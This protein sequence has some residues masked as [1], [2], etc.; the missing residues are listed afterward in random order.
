M[1]TIIIVTILQMN[2]LSPR[3]GDLGKVTQVPT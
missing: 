1:G 3:K 2:K